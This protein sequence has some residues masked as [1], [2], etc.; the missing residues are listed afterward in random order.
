MSGSGVSRSDPTKMPF[1]QGK[2]AASTGAVSGM[3]PIAATMRSASKRSPSVR[4]TE[5]GVRCEIRASKRKATPS[6][7]CRA[8][9][10]SAIAG[11]RARAAARGARPDEP[12]SHVTHGTGLSF[13]FSLKGTR[14]LPVRQDNPRKPLLPQS[15]AKGSLRQDAAAGHRMRARLRGL[16]REEAVRPE[17]PCRHL[18]RRQAR[19]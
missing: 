17:P 6:A 7:R 16:S 4:C 1:A 14:R 9:S 18:R 2:P 8:T 15:W 13:E 11:A 5:S 12:G 3:T 10:R 19:P